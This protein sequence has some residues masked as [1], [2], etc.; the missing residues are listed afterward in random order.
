MSRCRSC[1]SIRR[2]ANDGLK[3]LQVLDGFGLAEK[4]EGIAKAEEEGQ[5]VAG[6]LKLM[7][8][9]FAMGIG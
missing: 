2:C 4:G 9:K 1:C 8:L 5:I 6:I 7:T 3:A